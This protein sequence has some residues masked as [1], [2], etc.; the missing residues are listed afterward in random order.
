MKVNL[1]KLTIITETLLSDRIVELIKKHGATGYTLTRVEGEGSRGDHT[2]DWEGRNTKIEIL[3]AAETADMILTD[4]NAK[5]FE[6]FSVVAWLSEVQV[7][8]GEKFIK[9]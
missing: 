4:L 8:R 7:L 2:S 3:V 6:D 1:T 9:S 5:Y